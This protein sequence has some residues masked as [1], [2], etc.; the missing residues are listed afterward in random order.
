MD[1]YMVN[2]K[3]L[4]FR[5]NMGGT[6]IVVEKCE[7]LYWMEYKNNMGF[8]FKQPHS[9]DIRDLVIPSW[10]EFLKDRIKNFLQNNPEKLED[11]YN[12]K[13]IEVD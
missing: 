13:I 3:T 5:I 9:V 10:A 12:N 7:I 2:R 6:Y 8:Y 11:A 1:D 4:T